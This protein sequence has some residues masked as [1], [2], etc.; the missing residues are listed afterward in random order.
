M[1]RESVKPSEIL[2]HSVQ[3]WAEKIRQLAMTPIFP[4]SELYSWRGPYDSNL[5]GIMRGVLPILELNQRGILIID[6]IQ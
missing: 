6:N 3:L 4:G 2:L 1:R 5:L